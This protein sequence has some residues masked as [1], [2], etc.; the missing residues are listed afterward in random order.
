M[1]GDIDNYT[2]TPPSEYEGTDV[3]ALLVAL[4]VKMHKGGNNIMV[5]NNILPIVSSAYNIGSSGSKFASVNANIGNFDHI[6]LKTFS[7]L[8]FSI[9]FIG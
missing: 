6:N 9:G 7:T 8:G 2:P 4:S 3:A 1:S 5:N